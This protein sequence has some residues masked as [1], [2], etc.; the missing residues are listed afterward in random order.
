MLFEKLA[1]MARRQGGP[2]TPGGGPRGPGA[3]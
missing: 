1:F 2:G 3:A